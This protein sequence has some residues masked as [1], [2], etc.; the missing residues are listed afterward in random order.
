M[1]EEVTEGANIR[2]QRRGAGLPKRVE[3]NA[4][5][6]YASK[7]DRLL[8]KM[9]VR[10]GPMGHEIAEGARLKD[11]RAWEL[12]TATPLLVNLSAKDHL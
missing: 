2:S 12:K 5:H 10:L 4:F 1:A 9:P 3:D 11:S 7:V 8:L 6:R